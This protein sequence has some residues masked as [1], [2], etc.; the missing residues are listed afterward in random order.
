MKTLYLDIFSGLSGDMFIGALLDLGVDAHELGHEL[1]KLGLDDYHLHVSRQERGAISGTKFDVHL[2][3]EHEGHHG[4]EHSHG[5]EALS[6]EHSHDHGAEHHDHLAGEAHGPHGGPL[7]E[8]KS[9]RVELSVF[10]TGV[11]PRFRLYFYDAISPIV[12][13]DSINYDI[14][15]RA[16]RYGK[17]QTR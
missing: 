17:S 6:H 14:A 12:E 9:G 13:A 5:D 10:E 3:E 16:S 2:A 4:H 15:Y 1:E 7:L 8:T 11:P